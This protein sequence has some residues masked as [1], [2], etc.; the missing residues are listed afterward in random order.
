MSLN[1]DAFIQTTNY[2]DLDALLR[3]YIGTVKPHLDTLRQLAEKDPAK[4]RLLFSRDSVMQN[5]FKIG[6]NL[7]EMRE[8]SK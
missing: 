8:L 1:H 3:W 7:S 6:D 5:L 4:A 2:S